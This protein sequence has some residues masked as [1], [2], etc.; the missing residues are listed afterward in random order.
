MLFKE[1]KKRY[2]VT[3]TEENVKRLK[4]FIGEFGLSP[5]EF[6]VFLDSAVSK[7]LE[8]I[9]KLYADKQRGRQIEI[10]DIYK[11]IEASMGDGAKNFTS[12]IIKKS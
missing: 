7:A 3:L 6:S 8:D 11:K 1:K 5:R 12:K 9:E 10:G 4:W 2:F